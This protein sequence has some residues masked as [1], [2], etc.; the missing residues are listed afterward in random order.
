MAKTWVNS[1]EDMKSAGKRHDHDPPLILLRKKSRVRRQNLK[2]MTFVSLHG[3]TTFSYLDGVH[4]PEAHIRRAAE[5]KMSK[6]A[7]TEHGNIASHIKA[8]KS[9]EKSGVEIIYGCEFYTGRVGDRAKQL[10]YH[11]TVLAKDAV[12]Y[13]NLVK[14]VTLSWAEGFYYSPTISMKM[15]EEHKEGLIILSGCQGSLLHCAAVGGKMINREDASYARAKKVAMDFKVRFGDSYY[16]EVQAFPELDLCREFNPMAGRMAQELAIPLC[17][18]MDVH[19]VA[20]EDQELQK[21]LHNVRGRGKQSLE[22]MARAWGYSAPLCPPPNDRAIFRRLCQTGLTASLA[23]EAITNTSEIADECKVEL[24][25]LPMV[26]YPVPRGYKDALEVFDDWVRRG[27]AFRGFDKLDKQARERARKQVRYERGIMVEKNFIDYHLIISDSVR[28][29]KNFRNDLFPHGIPVGPGRGSA[30]GSLVCYLLRITEINPLEFPL[31]RFERYIDLSRDDFPDIDLDFAS[32]GRPIIREYMEGKYGKECVNSVGS[33]TGY[34]AKNSLDDVARVYRIPPWKVEI[35]K[36]LLVERSSGDLRA[37]ATVED[38]VSMFPQAAKVFEEHPELAHAMDIEG[39]YKG[40][41]VHSAGLV[42][43]NGPISDF[44]SF[45]V[46]EVPKDSGNWVSVVIMDKYDAERQGLIKLDYLGLN[47]MSMIASALKVLDMKLDDLYNIPHDDPKVIDVFNRNDTVGIFQFDGR[48]TRYVCGAVKPESFSEICDINALSRPGPLHNGAAREYAEVKAGVREPERLHASL[49]SITEQTRFQII[50]Q[51]QIL[52]VV[53]VLGNFDWTHASEIR[54]IIARKKGDAAFNA[55]RGRFL[56]GTRSL[57]RR[58]GFPKLP[59]PLAERI[60]GS[61]TTSGSYAFNAAHSTCYGLIAYWCGWLKAHHPTVF[62]AAALD[63]LAQDKKTDLLRDAVKHEIEVR[64][65][66]I[67]RSSARWIPIKQ[68]KAVL[69]GF[70][71]LPGVGA[72]TSKAIIEFAAENKC[73]NWTDLKVING[74]GPKTIAKITEFA[75][76]EDPFDIYKLERHIHE[77][78]E[79]LRD[80]GLPYPTHTS[81]DLPYEQGHEF[82]VVWLGTVTDRNIRD[83]FEQNRART[84]EELDPKDVKDPHLN[85]WAQLTGLDEN[86]QLLIKIDRWRYPKF[87]KHVFECKMN[88]DLIL[89]EGVRPRYVTARQVKVKQMWVL[90]MDD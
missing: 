72:K 83:I 25:K 8:E 89:V 90:E 69:A 87:K 48:A 15:L 78:K 63:E 17:A 5:L 39:N 16:I 85:E 31:L 57:H 47:T 59:D 6:I 60:W 80:L 21:I 38:T 68:K 50:Y 81:I 10:K 88:E 64:P 18:T 26:R 79:Q 2:P 12:G 22:D 32:E 34:K 37:S 24:P 65:P 9:A 54:R 41:G 43:S 49:D 51:E 73:N 27:W 74:V 19:Y 84:G 45:V 58:T 28:F 76:A 75:E 82:K 4:L 71:Q 44:C 30:A 33:F 53:R 35:V 55:E 13:R 86:D 52:E 70:E 42:I 1:L 61:L 66:N 62:Y 29:A 20:L 56:R 77:T 7:F 14:L 3:H 46:K 67:R 40:E 23:A 11:L 36:G